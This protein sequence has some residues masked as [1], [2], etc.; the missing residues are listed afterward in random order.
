MRDIFGTGV[1]DACLEQGISFDYGIGVSAGSGNLA[2]FMS[3]QKGRNKRFYL[4]YAQRKEYMSFSNWIRKGSYIDLDYVY[5]TLA[6]TD[7]EDPM[8]YEAFV[9]NPMELEV[10]STDAK[11]GKPVYFSKREIPLNR[12]DVFKASSCIPLLCKPYPIQDRIC[13]DGGLS[14]PIPIQRAL[15]QGCDKIVLILTKP[16]E[17]IRDPKKDVWPSRLLNRSYPESAKSLAYRARMYNQSLEYARKLEARGKVC[18][19]APYTI[20]KMKTLSLD[21]SALQD[22]YV[23]GQTMINDIHDFLL[24]R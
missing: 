24:Q 4:Q 11:T 10:V 19:V 14:D 23:Q 22:L 20:G 13:F 1:L 7:G 8:N 15:K 18:I 5:G 21:L 16:K 3:G 12:Y 2:S 6:N 17:Q 9:E